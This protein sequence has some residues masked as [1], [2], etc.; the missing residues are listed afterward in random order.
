M[1]IIVPHTGFICNSFPRFLVSS[2]P[3]SHAPRGNALQ[4]AP[5]PDLPGLYLTVTRGA[6]RL[7]CVPTRRV[8]TGNTAYH[9]L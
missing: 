3:R 9:M 6:A 8:G 2:F 5:R 7:D 1:Q 4:D